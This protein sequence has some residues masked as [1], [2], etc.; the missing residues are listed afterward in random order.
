MDDRSERIRANQE[1]L[2]HGL[3]DQYDFIICGS[4]SSG[5]VIARRLAENADVSVLLLEA[6]GTDDL[7]TIRDA[8]QYRSNLGTERDWGFVSQPNPAL[9]GRRLGMS[10]GRVLGG[11]SSINAAYWVRG[12]K[13]D[14]DFFAAESGDPRWGY[15]AMR[16]TFRRIENWT[17]APDPAYRGT[18]GPMTITSSATG[19][20]T[21]QAM[22]DAVRSTGIEI[23]DNLNGRL[24][25]APGGC[26]WREQNVQHVQGGPSAQRVSAFRAYTYPLMDRPN[27]TV[28]TSALVTRLTF[29]GRRASGVEIAWNDGRRRIGAGREVMICQGAINTPKLLMQSGIGDETELKRLGIPLRQHLPGVGRNFQDHPL[30]CAYASADGEQML[31]EP[32]AIFFCKSDATLD[33]PDI[34]G[35]RLEGLPADTPAAS[36]RD[37]ALKAWRVVTAIVG[38]RSRGYLRLTGREALDPIEIHSNTFG[39]PADLT[40]ALAAI[41]ICREI[42]SAEALRPYRGREIMPAAATGEARAELIRDTTMTIWHQ[43][44]TAKMGR[45]DMSVVDGALRVYGVEGLRIADASIM[46]R[47]TAGNTMAPCIAIGER[48]ADLVR[49]AHGV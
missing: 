49:A 26:S 46:P 34:Q 20:S 27:L 42:G 38:P 12:H 1:K 36:S 24:W 33:R 11:G 23:F 30:F 28:L 35:I 15:E 18:G 19:S 5:S 44:C 25:A 3:K 48:A 32:V 13:N 9:N 14:W 43:S 29:D 40:A 41:E 10:M 47:I 16:E 8:A 31:D 17:G 7:P 21:T 22:F 2:V 39:D 4:G 45:D 37:P 6:G